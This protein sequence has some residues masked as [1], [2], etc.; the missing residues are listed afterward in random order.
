M[1]AGWHVPTFPSVVMIADQFVI[2]LVAPD[3]SR[4]EMNFP[5]KSAGLF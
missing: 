3:R 5:R 2:L 4:F 1:I